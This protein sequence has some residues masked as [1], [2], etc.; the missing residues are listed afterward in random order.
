MDKVRGGTP[1]GS[2]SICLGCRHAFVIKGVNNQQIVHCQPVEK[3]I[4]FPVYECSQFDDKS[5][6]PLYEMQRI[7]WTVHSRNRGPMGFAD[8]RQLEVV[9]EPPTKGFQEIPE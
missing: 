9:I 8:G 1:K 5:Q 3:T 7:A 2:D 6:P 4:R